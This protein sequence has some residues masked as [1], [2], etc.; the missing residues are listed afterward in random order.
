MKLQAGGFKEQSA[1]KSLKYCKKF[2]VLN[3]NTGLLSSEGV[4]TFRC[5]L[6]LQVINSVVF[7]NSNLLILPKIVNGLTFDP[8]RDFR[9][10]QKN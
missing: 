10:G 1:L 7:K 4:F 9:K 3:L 8:S 2:N 6:L 5:F